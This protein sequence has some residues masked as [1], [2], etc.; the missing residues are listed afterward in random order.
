[1]SDQSGLFYVDGSAKTS[2]ESVRKSALSAGRGILRVCPGLG[3]RVAANTLTY[4][5][6]LSKSY[7]PQVVFACTRDCLYLITLDRAS[8]GKPV[9]A[10]RGF[11]PASNAP[12]IVMLPSGSAL[13]PGVSYRLR[14]RLVAQTN[15]GPIQQYSSPLLTV[16]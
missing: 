16:G 15:P 12:T 9:L 11:L 2:A 4:P 14:V 5:L 7:P 8:D 3:A 13:S 6:Q 1:M 10:R